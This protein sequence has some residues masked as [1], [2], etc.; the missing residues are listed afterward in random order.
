MEVLIFDVWT[1]FAQ[2]FQT[3]CQHCGILALVGDREN[4]I[5]TERH[6]ALFNWPSRKPAVM[7]TPTTEAELDKL[8]D[9]TFVEL[10]RR[11]GCAGCAV[12]QKV[13]GRHMRLPQSVLENR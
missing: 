3:L 1:A 7:E 10:S 6:G 2:G 5:A 4:T 13:F 11:V 12:G 8:T 9:F